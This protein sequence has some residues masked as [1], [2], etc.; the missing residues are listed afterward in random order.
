MSTTKHERRVADMLYDMGCTNVSI[1]KGRV[2]T[3]IHV[4]LPTGVTRVIVC[5]KSPKD[6]DTALMQTRRVVRRMIQGDQ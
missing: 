4:T 3:K 2:H 6:E 5:S 1:N